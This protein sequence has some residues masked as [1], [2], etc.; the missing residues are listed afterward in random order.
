MARHRKEHLSTMPK[1]KQTKTPPAASPE[2]PHKNLTQTQEEL[3]DLASDIL[4]NGGAREDVDLLL[5][6]LLRHRLVRKSFAARE[7]EGGREMANGH[8]E[9]FREGYYLELAK[10]WPVKPAPEPYVHYSQR[11]ERPVTEMVRANIREKFMHAVKDFLKDTDGIEPIWL[12]KEVLEDF[13][14]GDDLCDAVWYAF[15]RA[16]M[17]VRVPHRHKERIEAFVKLLEGAAAA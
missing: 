14:N 6:A 5:T 16:D 11:P 9:R 1:A 17:Y 7:E 15:D 12:L 3:A 10:N 2:R 13:N 4:L 8:A